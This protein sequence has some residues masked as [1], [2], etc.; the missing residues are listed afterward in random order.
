MGFPRAK[1]EVQKYRRL[2][3]SHRPKVRF[4]SH[5]CLAVRRDTAHPK[6]NC[7]DG[8]SDFGRGGGFSQSGQTDLAWGLSPGCQ[9]HKMRNILPKLP[10]VMQGQIETAGLAGLSR[11]DPC[12][13]NQARARFDRT[14]S[15]S[16]SGSD[17]VFGAGP[18]GMCDLSAFPG[19]AS[20][21]DSNDQSAGAA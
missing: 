4:L 8:I 1:I 15:R 12:A 11:L 13:G 20:C 7:H 5:R 18:G 21:A 3:K 10:R 6:K 14:V 9:V 16:L 19:C 2:P 17:G